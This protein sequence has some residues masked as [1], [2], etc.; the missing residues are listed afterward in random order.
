LAKIAASKAKL[1]KATLKVQ[2]V[3]AKI[4]Q[5]RVSKIEA[6]IAASTDPKRK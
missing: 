2:R 5:K 6:K 1:A 3:S 4:A